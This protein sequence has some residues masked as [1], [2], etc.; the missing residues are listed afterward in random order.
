[1]DLPFNSGKA[2]FK[3]ILRR[4]QGFATLD[5]QN[6]ILVSTA[7]MEVLTVT[8]IYNIGCSECYSRDDLWHGSDDS[9]KD[10]QHRML[11]M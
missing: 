6:A 8:R 2:G 11:R 3:W 9:Y 7:E 10:L 4:L 5:A 1:M